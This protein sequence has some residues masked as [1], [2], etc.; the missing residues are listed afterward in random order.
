M[1]SQYESKLHLNSG[2]TTYIDYKLSKGKRLL[3]CFVLLDVTS[4]YVWISD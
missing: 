3:L 2:K 4:K 1:I